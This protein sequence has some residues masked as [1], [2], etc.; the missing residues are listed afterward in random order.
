MSPTATT[1]W[2]WGGVGEGVG[3]GDGA[4]V[5]VVPGGCGVVGVVGVPARGGAGDDGFGLGV[6][7]Q[8]WTLM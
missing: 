6:L 7:T 5:V 3:D 2:S 1:T 8:R 4:V